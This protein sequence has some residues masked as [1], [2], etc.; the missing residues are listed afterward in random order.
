MELEREVGF[1]ELVQ[2]ACLWSHRDTSKLGS[3][4]TLTGWGVLEQGMSSY[5]SHVKRSD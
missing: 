1:N 5:Q 4:A 2:P 3:I